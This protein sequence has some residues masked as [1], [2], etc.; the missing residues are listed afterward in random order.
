MRIVAIIN[1]NVNSITAYN[2]LSACCRLIYI[3]RG[4]PG[5]VVTLFSSAPISTIFLKATVLDLL[6]NVPTFV[7]YNY[8]YYSRNL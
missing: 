2:E 7:Y 8:Y 5:M 3:F 6:G 1:N 4:R